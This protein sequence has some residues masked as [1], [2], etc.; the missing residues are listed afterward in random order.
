MID[1]TATTWCWKELHELPSVPLQFEQQFTNHPDLPLFLTWAE[2][3]RTITKPNGTSVS[4]INYSRLK[5]SKELEDWVQTNICSKFIHAA[6]SVSDPGGVTDTHGP[7]V[8]GSRDV[9]IMWI[10][11]TGGPTVDTVFWEVLNEP[12]VSESRGKWLD[13]YNNLKE[14][15]KVRFR[16]RTWYLL[17][18][19]IMHSVENLQ[20][21]RIVLQVSLGYKDLKHIRMSVHDMNTK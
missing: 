7:H 14:Y 12:L 5:I 1:T 11:D 17:N 15:T 19:R 20:S 2:S 3:N 10:H 21:P 8:D 9:T 18:T 6:I 13:T 4:N 16:P